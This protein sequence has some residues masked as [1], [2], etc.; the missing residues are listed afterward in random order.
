MRER[1]DSG[2]RVKCKKMVHEI[3]DQVSSLVA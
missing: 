3:G 1:E 2:K